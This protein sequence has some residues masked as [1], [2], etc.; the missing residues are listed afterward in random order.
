M[1]E[2]KRGVIGSYFYLRWYGEGASASNHQRFGMSHPQV[3]GRLGLQRT[4]PKYQASDQVQFLR[5]TLAGFQSCAT[6]QWSQNSEPHTNF[7]RLSL[8]LCVNEAGSEGHATACPAPLVN[9]CG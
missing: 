9:A 3:V 8:Y 6:C 5:G 1:K 7:R 4:G 2:L